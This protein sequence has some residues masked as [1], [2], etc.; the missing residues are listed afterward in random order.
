MLTSFVD[1]VCVV[2]VRFQQSSRS[3]LNCR[4]VSGVQILRPRKTDTS[5]QTSFNEDTN[6]N[7]K[8]NMEQEEK[9]HMI[10]DEFRHLSLDEIQRPLPME[11]WDESDQEHAHYDTV[12]RCLV[13]K[14]SC[15]METSARVDKAS[16][17]LF[18]L[19]FLLYNVAYWV[20]YYHGIKILPYRL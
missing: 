20:T 12:V 9:F 4:Y 10:N 16:R 2:A 1:F 17:I 6:R 19:S 15:P 5:T 11:A 3:G 18:P 13:K 8:N 7:Q 14:N